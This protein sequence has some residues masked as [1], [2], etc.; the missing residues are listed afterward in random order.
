MKAPAAELLLDSLQK[1]LHVNPVGISGDEDGAATLAPRLTKED[2]RI[3]WNSPSVEIARRLRVLGPLWS[4]VATR[5][6]KTERIIMR[7]VEETK[8]PPS[9]GSEWKTVVCLGSAGEDHRP[10][11]IRYLEEDDG[12]VVVALPAGGTLRI[13]EIVVGGK[14]A[15]RAATTFKSLTA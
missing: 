11:E 15:R 7:D 10:V 2:R 13:R 9:E 3:N 4:E 5:D 12:A 1:G 14:G 6:G 8:V